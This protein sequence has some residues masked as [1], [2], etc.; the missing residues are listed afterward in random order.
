M[1]KRIGALVVALLVLVCLLA[2]PSMA[3][4][5]TP[6]LQAGYAKIKIETPTGLPMGGYSDP[7]RVNESNESDLYVTCIA[8]T[9]ANGITALF[10]GVDTQNTNQQWSNSAKT[11]I[12]EALAKMDTPV[13][14]DPDRIYISASGS[15]STPL[16]VYTGTDAAV[17]EAVDAYRQVVISACATAATNAMA[18]RRVVTMSV[19]MIDTSAALATSLGVADGAKETRLNYSTHVRVTDQNGNSWVAGNGFGPVSAIN[20][21]KYTVAEVSAPNDTLGLLQF[22][23][24]D[25]SEPIVLANWS[26]RA[27]LS[28]S[29]NTKYG[30]LHH[31]QASSDYIGYFRDA[32]TGM[33]T[34]FF[35]STAGNVSAFSIDFS[36]QNPNVM[37]AVTYTDADGNE[38]TT[39]SVTA[40]KYGQALA[41]LALEGLQ[42]S[43]TQQADPSIQNMKV[44]F[45]SE[46]DVPTLEQ[47]SLVNALKNTPYNAGGMDLD[48][49]NDGNEDEPTYANLYEFL[50]ANW[51]QKDT[52]VDAYAGLAD[53]VHPAELSGINTRMSHT[54]YETST[55]FATDAIYCDTT[56]LTLGEVTFAMAPA[57]LY[58]N[59]GIGGQYTWADSGVDF[60]L[61]ATNGSSGYLVSAVCYEYNAGMQNVPN[62]GN[63]YYQGTNLTITTPFPKGVGERLMETYANIKKTL[64]ATVDNENNKIRMM[65]EC[66]GLAA[67]KPDHTCEEKAF[68]PW[69]DPDSL[70]VDGNYYLMT[71]VRVYQEGRTG[72]AQKSFDLNGHTITRVVLP[73][74]LL[75]QTLP[76]DGA[77]YYP[78]TRLFALESEARL[79]ITDTVGGGKLTRDISHLDDY[80]TNDNANISN[81]GLLIAIIDGNTSGAILYNGVLDASGQVAGGGACVANMSTK[82]TFTMYDGEMIGGISDRGNAFYG[83]GTNNFY[84]GTFTAA[85]AGTN[86]VVNMVSTGK[87]LLAGDTTIT[88]N[89]DAQ[90]KDC[91]LSVGSQCLTVDPGYTGAAGISV[92]NNEDP[93]GIIIGAKGDADDAV[94]AQLTVDNFP[95]YTITSC[96]TFI[97]AAEIR[98]YCICGGTMDDGTHGH[99]MEPISWKPW[100]VALDTYLPDATLG[101]NYYLL[102][103]IT[104]SKQKSVQADFRIDLNGHNITRVVDPA[105]EN[106]QSVTRVFSLDANGSLVITDSS[107]GQPGVI[108]RDLSKLSEEQ[109]KSI[110]NWGLIVLIMETATG[111]FELFN[112]ILD[113]TGQ[114]SGGGACVANLNATSY[115]HMHNGALKGGISRTA[116]CIYSAGPVEIHGGTITGG[117]GTGTGIGGVDIA[118]LSTGNRYGYLYLCSDASIYGNV[119]AKGN[120]S[121][122]RM[123]EGHHHLTIIGE[124]T[125]TAGIILGSEPM[126]NMPIA[127]SDGAIID[128]A[129][130]TGD[131]Y[132][133]G[134]TLVVENGH[135]VMK[136]AAASVTDAEGNVTYFDTLNEAFAAD[137]AENTVITLLRP[138]DEA[139]LTLTQDTYLDLKGWDLNGAAFNKNGYNLYI[140][141]TETDDY[142]INKGQQHYA[143]NGEEYA[144]TDG[145]GYGLVTGA[146]ATGAVGAGE[147][148]NVVLA[149]SDKPIDLYLKLTETDGT[150]FH[151]L[152]L[153]F[154]G[155]TLRPDSGKDGSYAPGLYYNSQFGGDEVIVRNMTAY[156]VGMSAI[157]GETMFTRDKSYTELD[158]SSWKTGCD[159]YGNSNNVTNGTILTGIMK[160][161]NIDAV[162]RRN[163]TRQVRGQNYILLNNGTR[164]VGPEVSFSLQDVFEGN[165]INGVDA[166]FPTMSDSNKTQILTLYNNYYNVMKYWALPNLKEAA[167]K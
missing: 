127:V 24:A 37:E 34:A 156:G 70:P 163:G 123:R 87:L 118:K 5:A 148:Y 61:G 79:T 139:S 84:G 133:E 131:N 138:V 162:N 152:N 109:K 51:D 71:D 74:V 32:M 143:F 164:V 91:N 53:L 102:T 72:T 41:A 92:R 82:A 69:Y 52:Y 68:L 166:T 80:G 18:D 126:H 27:N 144:L 65:C 42:N 62:N 105:D 77:I 94:L 146:V 73:E 100:P 33:R 13:Q 44:R 136:M 135:I 151:R 153:R 120:P 75:D 2:L 31:N 85:T 39:D 158:A 28:S 1:K 99:T 45:A 10:V 43:M 9:D 90:G 155:L 125:G 165:N 38:Q 26:A 98:E 21:N 11:A 167:G 108:T 16:L 128:N 121:N 20:S 17:K 112:G 111:D 58:D 7:S 95:T 64:N 141:D 149:G 4:E 23:P 119:D 124:Y 47:V 19:G 150:S 22:T 6:A 57:D 76:F 130:L 104:I 147:G 46:P 66:G 78:H 142:T 161:T 59:Y 110:D 93:N 86:G 122:I 55:N 157:E 8:L 96:Q 134:Y 129:T 63:Y 97:M 29:A 54:I 107:D 160:S 140:L 103:D 83:N 137:I 117:V 40:P 60:I 67:G 35:V 115:F 159:Q 12:V 14:M 154:A 89:K 15:M 145:R 48:D 81:Y 132:T 113:A 25:G 114:V 36:E 106:W 116:G 3:T 30:E 88:G 49:E 56:I 50:L 101:G